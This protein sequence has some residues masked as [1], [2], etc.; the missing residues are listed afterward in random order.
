[1]QELLHNKVFILCAMA[2]IIFAVTQVLKL[3]IKFFT[4]KIK[5][6]TTRKR[7]NATI[8]LIPFALGILL[9]FFYGKYVTITPFNVI[10][11][12]GYGFSGISLYSIIERFFG[13]KTANPYETEEGRAVTELISKVSADGKVD[14][15]DH[16]A[17]KAFWDKVK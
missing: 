4:N 17:V 1:M 14:E 10:T 3:P 13:I 2:V 15:N 8:L 11:G 6:Q 16:D 7:V 9:E 12:L 5:N